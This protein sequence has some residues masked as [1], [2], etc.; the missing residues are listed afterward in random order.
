MSSKINTFAVH[1]DNATLYSNFIDLLKIW[2]EIQ[3]SNV[4]IIFQ[5]TEGSILKDDPIELKSIVNT[6][7]SE[8]TLRKLICGEIDNQKFKISKEEEIELARH[9]IV[10]KKTVN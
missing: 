6:N 2:A 10:V 1:S 9:N 8:E 7:H 4:G 5:I 3:N